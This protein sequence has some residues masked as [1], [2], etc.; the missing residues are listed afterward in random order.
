MKGEP[1]TPL[2]IEEYRDVPHLALPR[3]RRKEEEE[4]PLLPPEA[5]GA[6]ARWPVSYGKEDSHIFSFSH[7][8]RV[9]AAGGY[10]GW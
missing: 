4:K 2:E 7:I 9:L 8:L 3:Q 5:T 1:Q 10:E 6:E